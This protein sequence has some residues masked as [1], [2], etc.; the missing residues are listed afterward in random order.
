M[1]KSV[2]VFSHKEFAFVDRKIKW[3]K[4]SDGWWHGTIPLDDEVRYQDGG[5][6]VISSS[7]HIKQKDGIVEEVYRFGITVFERYTQEAA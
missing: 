6:M 1:D 7:K 3:S 5:R 2:R 4:W